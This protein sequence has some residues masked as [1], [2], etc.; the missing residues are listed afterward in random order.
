M[1][2][3]VLSKEDM[4]DLSRQLS[5]AGIMNKKIEEV[6]REVL[7]YLV[8]EGKYGELL[9]N[10]EGIRIIEESLRSIKKTYDSIIK[11]LKVEAEIPIEKFLENSEEDLALLTALIEAGA[12][13]E[14]NGRLRITSKPPLGDL[15][16]ELKFPIEELGDYLDS[17]E[18]RF[19]VKMVSEISMVKS[20]YVEVLEVDRELIEAALEIGKDYATE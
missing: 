13:K 12:L 8:I 11:P 16:I 17:L 20:Y 2:F 3:E 4:N 19:K 14:E 1:R 10:A 5:R 6:N 15:K 18:E 7:H 9:K